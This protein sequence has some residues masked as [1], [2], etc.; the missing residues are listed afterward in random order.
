VPV[1]TV[2]VDTPAKIHRWF[3]IV[4]EITQETGLVTSEIVPALRAT[5]PGIRTGGLRLAQRWLG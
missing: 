4:D 2:I 5:A 1:L 3:A